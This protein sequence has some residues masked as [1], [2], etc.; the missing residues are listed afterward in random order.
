MPPA[1]PEAPATFV[2]VSESPPH[3]PPDSS[4]ALPAVQAQGRPR[5]ALPR[6][7]PAWA[8]QPLPSSQHPAR[9]PD[10]VQTRHQGHTNPQTPQEQVYDQ[11]PNPKPCRD[12]VF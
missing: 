6:P 5:G 1:S 4:R 11:V 12:D 9:A 10:R 2:L 7:E 8:F 3:R